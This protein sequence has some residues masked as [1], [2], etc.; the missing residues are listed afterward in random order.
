MVLSDGSYKLVIRFRGSEI[1]VLYTCMGASPLPLPTGTRRCVHP[2]ATAFARTR[3]RVSG[4]TTPCP[5]LDGRGV[6][7]DPWGRIIHM[8][9]FSSESEGK[10][11]AHRQI[12]DRN[13]ARG[14]SQPH[15]SYDDVHCG[16]LKDPGEHMFKGTEYYGPNHQ[17]KVPPTAPGPRVTPRRSLFLLALP[18]QGCVVGGD[19][20]G[21]MSGSGSLGGDAK[22]LAVANPGSLGQGDVFHS[23]KGWGPC[24]DCTKNAGRGPWLK[25]YSNILKHPLGGRGEGTLNDAVDIYMRMNPIIDNRDQATEDVIKNHPRSFMW[26]VRFQHTPNTL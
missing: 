22:V 18:P 13:R 1:G 6:A 2:S 16:G 20:A 23:T 15:S 12:A 17:N 26:V 9:G 4:T 19:R 7:A 5:R 21:T 11:V 24:V 8:R 10:R 25:Q 3:R 14:K